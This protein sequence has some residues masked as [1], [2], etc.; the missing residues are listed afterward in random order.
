MTFFYIILQKGKTKDTTQ[1]M[2]LLHIMLLR[3]LSLTLIVIYRDMENKVFGHCNFLLYI[4]YKTI[5]SKHDSKV[6]SFSILMNFL[7]KRQN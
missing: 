6:N 5:F 4:S 7:P 2:I 1:N 3:F